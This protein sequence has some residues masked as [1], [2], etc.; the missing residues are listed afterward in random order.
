M[1]T[2]PV[3]AP[4]ADLD[5]VTFDVA[6]RAHV[7]RT[8]RAGVE[9]LGGRQVV[10]AR[11][12]SGHHRGALA[13][14][15]GDTITDAAELALAQRLPLVMV[16]SSSGSDVGDG[17]GALH[18]WGRAAAAV[19]GCS[20]AVPVLAAMVG[21]AIS[22]PALLLGLADVTAMTPNAF[23]FLSGPE[24]VEGFT[25]V[26]VGLQDL[27]GTAVH[28]TA[29]GLCALAAT[30]PGSAL[31]LLGEVLAYLPDHADDLPAV[32]DTDD[33][34]LRPTPELREALPTTANASYDVR[35]IVRTVA[36]DGE[37]LE[38]RPGWAPQLVTG[39]ASIGGI[40]LGVV[41]NQ[42][43]AMAG[44][45]DIAASQ[46]GARF[47]RFCDAFNL[48]L[49]TLVDTPG[50]LPGK[51][52]EWRGMIRH[53]AELAF[54]YAEATVP[55][56]CLVLRKAY[57]GA[58]IVMDSKGI[59]NDVCLAWP[60]AEIAVMGATGAVQILNRGADV[61]ERR[62]L[63]DRY[64]EELLTPWVGAERGFVDDVVDPADTRAVLA[65]TVALLRSR[66]ELLV[67]RKHDAGPL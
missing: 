4:T 28:T 21:P 60:S 19:A 20:G 66:R 23:A 2:R 64:S 56:V 31:D 18:G 11:S 58:Y 10:S 54:A 41:A 15:D 22:G 50:F 36:D 45:L 55:R 33:D 6:V 9:T 12:V 16:L 39:L 38:L 30:D 32:L 35:D 5:P 65:R 14:T 62:A 8:V 48:P 61:D 51:D 53:G 40:P 13:E 29:S 42:P 3:I 1:S 37:L 27:G 49:L 26:R 52:L 67:G 24:A 57:G 25:G 7:P 47:V 17:I 43:R 59:G 34:P 44:T 46:K 63:E